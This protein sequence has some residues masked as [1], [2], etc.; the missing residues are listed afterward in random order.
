MKYIASFIGRD[1]F[2]MEKEV[3]EELFYRGYIYLPE[4]L[5]LRV[6]ASDSNARLDVTDL[7]K[8]REFVLQRDSVKGKRVIRG[9]FKE[10]W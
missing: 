6:S 10:R 1:G 5:P 8:R 9:T 4:K 3:P 7:F 2:V